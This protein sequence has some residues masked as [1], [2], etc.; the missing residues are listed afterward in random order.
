LVNG[1]HFGDLAASFFDLVGG[2]DGVELFRRYASL[3]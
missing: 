1:F 2:L 3:S